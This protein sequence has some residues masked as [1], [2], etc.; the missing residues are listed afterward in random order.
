MSDNPLGGRIL[1][2]RSETYVCEKTWREVQSWRAE[3]DGPGPIYLRIFHFHRNRRS[4]NF[5]M[6]TSK[7]KRSAASDSPSSHKRRKHKDVSLTTSLFQRGRLKIHVAVP[8]AAASSLDIFIQAHLTST[9]LL[10]HTENGTIVSFST[11]KPISHVGRILDECPFSWT[12]FEGEVVLFNPRIG[13][14]I[15]TFYQ[16]DADVGGTV[17]LSSPDHIALTTHA[18]FNVSIPRVQMPD[19]WTFDDNVWSDS[20]GNVID[21]NLEFEVTQYDSLIQ[22]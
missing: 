10:K 18:L 4:P 21:G 15:R 6:K 3:I 7:K 14:R 16:D 9:I 5:A 1:T 12:W 19:D 2:N 17:R 13:Q 8:S 20:D 11:F 22:H